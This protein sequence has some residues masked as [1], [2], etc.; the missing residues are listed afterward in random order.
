VVDITTLSLFAQV[1]L[2]VFLGTLF[3]QARM[4]C[5]EKN[6]YV[7]MQRRSE[8]DRMRERLV[9]IGSGDLHNLHS[10]SRPCI[11]FMQSYGNA[12]STYDWWAGNS[13]FVNQS[14]S[15]IAAH[16]AHAGLMRTVQ[17]HADLATIWS[18]QTCFLSISSL[19]D[20]ICGNALRA[21]GFDF[22]RVSK[23]LAAMETA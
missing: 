2:A 14:G 7:H 17:P 3:H 19:E 1:L 23:A 13:R 22:R 9:M 16:A 21:I 12:T 8:M 4:I 6:G 5:L 11:S 18:Y 10:L 20:V 15:F